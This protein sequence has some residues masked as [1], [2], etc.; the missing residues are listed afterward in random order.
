MTEFRCIEHQHY[1]QQRRRPTHSGHFDSITLRV[2]VVGKGQKSRVST[3]AFYNVIGC[4]LA[5][6]GVRRGGG[7]QRA[8][9]GGRSDLKSL[10]DGGF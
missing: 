7:V 4:E 8:H 9:M 10:I 2:K 5:R 3:A 6:R 1:Y